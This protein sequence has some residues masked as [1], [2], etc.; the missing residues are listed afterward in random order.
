MTISNK[1][2]TEEV[3]NTYF[4]LKGGTYHSFNIVKEIE[5]KGHKVYKE[6]TFVARVFVSTH[7]LLMW[8]I[9]KDEAKRIIA[10]KGNEYIQV[11]TTKNHAQKAIVQYYNERG[12]KIST[13]QAVGEVGSKAKPHKGETDVL[14]INI[15]HIKRIK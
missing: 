4:G 15:K 11:A 9:W 13:E 12:E 3:M 1:M 10:H 6:T 5:G 8:G 14:C 7:K 2:T